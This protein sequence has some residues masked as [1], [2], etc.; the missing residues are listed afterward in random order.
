MG[1]GAVKAIDAGALRQR[2]RSTAVV[3]GLGSEV[4]VEG[5]VNQDMYVSLLRLLVQL[6]PTVGGILGATV[7]LG[8]LCA[9]C[10]CP[11]R[12][13]S[14]MPAIMT[15][16]DCG[17]AGHLHSTAE[18]CAIGMRAPEVVDA[19]SSH[20]GTSQKIKEQWSSQQIT[21]APRGDFRQPFTRA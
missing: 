21:S 18:D 3:A 20:R 4:L 6:S 13:Q 12:R 8:F 14:V 7:V 11:A 17:L 15:T 1:A 5:R 9:F 10:I 19:C 16:G 2:W